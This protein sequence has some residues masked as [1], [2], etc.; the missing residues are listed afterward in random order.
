MLE[1]KMNPEAKV[2]DDHLRFI[3]SGISEILGS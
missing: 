2:I 3:A 1:D